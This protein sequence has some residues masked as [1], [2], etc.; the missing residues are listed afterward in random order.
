MQTQNLTPTQWDQLLRAGEALR[1]AGHGEK[2]TVASRLATGMGVS[3]GTLYRRLKEA[4]LMPKRKRRADAMTST[5][6]PEQAALIG[7]MLLASTNG[8]GQSMPLSVAADVLQAS[9]HLPDVSAST[10]SR[11]LRNQLM[12]P[13]Q[14][15]APKASVELKSEHPNHVWQIDSTT[16]AYYYLPGGRL[17]WMPED[18]FYKNKVQNIVKASTDLLTRYA[19]ADHASHCFKVRYYLG[20]ETAENLVDFCCWAMWKQDHSPMHGVPRILMMDPGAANKGL[21]M[22]NYCRR[23]GIQLLHHAA[24]AANVTGSVEKSHDLVRMHFETRLRFIDPGEVTLDKLNAMIAD[25]CAAYGS[26]AR[27]SRHKMDRHSAWLRIRQDQLR[28][29]TS[30]EALRDAATKEPETRR[31]SNDLKVQVGKHWFDVS[32]VP[33]ASAGQKILVAVNVFRHPSIDVQS[34]DRETGE[35]T[36]HIVDPVQVDEF[37]FSSTATVIGQEMRTARNTEVDDLR[38]DLTKQAYGL[39]T[40]EEAAQARKRHAQAYAGTVDVMA[41]VKATQVPDYMPRRGTPIGHEPRQLVAQLLTH[42]EA[43]KRLRITLGDA[44]GPHV[45]A[46][47]TQRHPDGVPEDQLSAI[48]AQLGIQAEPSNTTQA[49]SDGTTGLR[50]VR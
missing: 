7:G 40:L 3:V 18:E 46:W 24:G 5:V 30:L 27:H 31:V 15:A 23:L 41:D 34:V 44:Y 49:V 1:N 22:R 47:L 43:A 17:R 29:A 20:G 16:G 2:D 33:G 25:W 10:L 4:D 13:D 6:T 50:V 39:P 32:N 38:N 26:Q 48:T 37:G 35:E 11:V 8:K 28:V 19:A 36:W 42:V 9:G 14:L 45:Y 21:A 12:H